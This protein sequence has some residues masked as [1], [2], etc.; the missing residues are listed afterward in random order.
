MNIFFPFKHLSTLKNDNKKIKTITLQLIRLKIPNQT[1][2]G[3]IKLIMYSK[4]IVYI[5][6]FN[7]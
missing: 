5:N 1:F 4:H 3:M 6:V 7:L 2:L